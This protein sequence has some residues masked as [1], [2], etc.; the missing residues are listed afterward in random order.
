MALRLDST[1]EYISRTTGL[2]TNSSAYTVM[3]RVKQPTGTQSNCFFFATTSRAGSPSG[4]A[5]EGADYLFMTGGGVSFRCGS[6]ITG[7]GAEVSS[8]DDLNENQWYWVIMRRSSGTLLEFTYDGVA[9]DTADSTDKS[10]RAAS[11]VELIGALDTGL[12]TNFDV[13]HVKIWSVALSDSEIATERSYGN[14]VRTTNLHT[15]TPMTGPD[16]ATCLVSSTGSNWSATGT[17]SQV[18]GSGIALFSAG[19]TLTADTGVFTLTGVAATL[20]EQHQ[21]VA[22][23]ASFALTGN[24]AN[25]TYNGAPTNYTLTANLGLFSLNGQDAT[26]TYSLPNII[27]WDRVTGNEGYRIKWGSTSGTYPNSADTAT[28]VESYTLQMPYRTTWFYVV[29]AL[30]GGVEQTYSEEHV[31]TSGIPDLN[32]DVTPFTLTGNAANLVYGRGIAATT[33]SFSLTG[34][35]AALTSQHVLTADTSSFA[36]TG[37]NANLVYLTSGTTY[38]LTAS[39]GSFTLTGIDSILGKRSILTSDKTTYTFNGINVNLL[40]S[41]APIS[42]YHQP[43]MNISSMGLFL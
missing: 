7:T 1:S 36:L 20:T 41:G 35:T 37:N 38:T 30:V 8:G 39:P 32:A 15:Y 34:N 9:W 17:L 6:F 26:F 24:N 21:L 14:P 27:T 22:G 4:S 10:G 29:A 23:T 13:E 42:T 5:Y 33:G 43:C 16:V 40:Y 28:N 31:F 18:S 25:L 11:V 2:F 12:P 3:L 19:T